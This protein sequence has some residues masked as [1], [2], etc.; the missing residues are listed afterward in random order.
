M[1]ATDVFARKCHFPFHLAQY[2]VVQDYIIALFQIVTVSERM[3]V[4]KD[5][6][7]APNLYAAFYYW[8]YDV[9]WRAKFCTN[10]N[11]YGNKW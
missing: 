6:I 4:R 5:S 2:T 3:V 11:V 9:I 7:W 1:L 8:N 10:D